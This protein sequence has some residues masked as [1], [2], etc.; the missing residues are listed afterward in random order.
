MKTFEGLIEGKQV[1]IS[2]LN[3]EA[4][5][6]VHAE[7]TG[8]ISKSIPELLEGA[9]GTDTSQLEAFGRAIQ[10]A[11]ADQGAGKFVA[12]IKKALL[13]GNIILEGKRLSH[14][15]DCEQWEDVDGSILMYEIFAEWLKLNF[16]SLLK[17]LGTSIG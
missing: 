1:Q 13:D 3:A 9:G 15:N 11:F 16:G 7:L 12:F 2:K 5:L 8:L 4:A 10:F 14:L 6:S 17:K